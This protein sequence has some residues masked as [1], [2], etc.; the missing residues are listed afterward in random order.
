VQ[1]ADAT[2]ISK[3]PLE[4]AEVIA[5]EEVSVLTKRGQSSIPTPFM[6]SEDR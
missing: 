4:Y 1:A 3:E 6:V 5:T 2:A